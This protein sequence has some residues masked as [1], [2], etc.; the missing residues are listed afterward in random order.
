MG[1]EDEIWQVE[2]D[3][4]IYETNLETLKQWIADGRV[5]PTHRIKKGD[6]NWIAANKAPMLR[7]EFAKIADGAPQ[8]MASERLDAQKVAGSV[9]KQSN[10]FP[11]ALIHA[12]PEAPPHQELNQ[13]CHFHPESEPQYVCRVC[14]KRFCGK[15][16]QFIGASRIPTCP[17]CGDLC[18]SIGLV[19]E[20]QSTSSSAKSLEKAVVQNSSFGGGILAKAL[21]YPFLF[22]GALI[23]ASFIYG[24]LLL[25]SL[26]GMRSGMIAVMLANGLLFG[27]LTQVV[28]QAAWGRFR[29]NFLGGFDSFSLW[30]NAFRPTFFGF[31]IIGVTFG[32]FLLLLIA[33]M[34]GWIG[35]PANI[36]GT[37]QHQIKEEQKQMI[38]GEEMEALLNSQGGEKEQKALEKLNQMTPAA[39][40]KQMVDEKTPKTGNSI[41]ITT[42]E[43][44]FSQAPGWI[45]GLLLFTLLWAVWYYPMALAVAGYSEDFGS[46][47]NP[48]VGLDTIKRM[49]SVYW[50][51]FMM[52]LVVQGIGL[53]L[54][55]LIGA[56]TASM[57]LPLIGNIPAK[58]LGGIV[59]FYS[60][61]VVAYILGLSLNHCAAQLNIPTD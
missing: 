12:E 16:P 5:L 60:S 43:E 6:L 28:K 22:P 30:E 7:G 26:V 35:N 32:P 48:L 18:L 29:V 4:Q 1:N 11:P 46:I 38:T 52:Y 57:S 20:E 37:Y 17:L 15:C 21:R 14:G 2:M 53:F 39:Q 9:S 56:V 61:L 47:L 58:I 10:P 23:G 51:V 44:F 27:C 40:A 50:R 59:T 55:Y 31:G 49:G 3:G 45:L 54:N 13:A 42:I 19:S 36:P 33:M 41:L 24:F 34:T 8:P 25:G